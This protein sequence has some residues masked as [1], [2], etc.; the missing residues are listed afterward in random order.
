ME[1]KRNPATKAKNKYNTANY[2]RLYPYVEKGRK[3]IYEREAKKAGYDSLNQFIVE[4]I[5]EKILRDKT[6]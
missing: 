4:A 6:T 5:E 1:K 3:E 2:D